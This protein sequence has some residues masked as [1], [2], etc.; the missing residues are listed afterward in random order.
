MV[1]RIIGDSPI[2]SFQA[3]EAEDIEVESGTETKPIMSD[4]FISYSRD[5]HAFVERRSSIHSQI[6]I[7]DPS[8]RETDRSVIPEILDD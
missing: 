7:D 2:G 4:L 6:G 3:I 8:Y 5:D 1:L